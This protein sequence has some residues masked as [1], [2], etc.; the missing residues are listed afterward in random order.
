MKWNKFVT[1][2]LISVSKSIEINKE[3]ILNR[4]SPEN[5]FMQNNDCSMQ[6]NTPVFR[7]NTNHCSTFLNITKPANVP[8]K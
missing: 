8:D 1:H 6:V 5:L 2:I 4:T 7:I 3:E